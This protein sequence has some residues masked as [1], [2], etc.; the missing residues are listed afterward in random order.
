MVICFRW[1][2]KRRAL[3][4]RKRWL[5][6]VLVFSTEELGS[7][8]RDSRVVGWH[9][10]GLFGKAMQKAAD[11]QRIWHVQGLELSWSS[12]S[13]ALSQLFLKFPVI[14]LEK[15]VKLLAE[16]KL[17]NVDVQI[18]LFCVESLWPV[19]ISVFPQFPSGHPLPRATHCYQLPE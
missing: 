5:F 11:E 6:N 10:P 2:Q 12:A 4:L 15:D 9:L 16:I 17:I 1:E 7:K 3:L 14:K 19:C 13:S 18:D 8:R